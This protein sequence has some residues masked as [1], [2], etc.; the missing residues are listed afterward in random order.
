[1]LNGFV[2]TGRAE[3]SLSNVTIDGLGRL[4]SAF[5]TIADTDLNPVL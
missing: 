5:E 3:F 2:A 4:R 1:M